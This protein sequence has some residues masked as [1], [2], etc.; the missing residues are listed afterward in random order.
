MSV[1]LLETF[2]ILCLC[3]SVRVIKKVS[4]CCFEANSLKEVS[5]CL[6][7]YIFPR[8]RLTVNTKFSL[9]LPLF[10][11]FVS[12]LAVLEFEAEVWTDAVGDT[13]AFSFTLSIISV[14][15]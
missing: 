5:K 7:L 12:G 6:S 4:F 14:N 2:L 15:L 1:P 9:P 10:H 11:A 13:F 3:D 8:I